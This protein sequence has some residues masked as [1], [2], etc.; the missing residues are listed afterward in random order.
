HDLRSSMASFSKLEIAEFQV[1]AIE[2]DQE[3]SALRLQ[4][5]VRYELVGS[6]KD[7]YREHRVG[8]WELNWEAASSEAA[9]L[10]TRWRAL[11]ETWSRATGP[12]FADIS[13]QALG[14][15]SSYSSQLLHGA[16]YWR[17]VL[18]V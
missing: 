4:T 5:R 18:H 2:L 15:N 14:G 17:S 6:G 3:Q 16:D 9:F 12:V 13:S 1:V 8:E 10:V 11:G 7:S